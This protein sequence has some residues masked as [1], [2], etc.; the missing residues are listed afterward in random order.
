MLKSSCVMLE[1]QIVDMEA[2]NDKM[3]EKETELRQERDGLVQEIN[4]NELQ[5][6]KTTQALES[7]KQAR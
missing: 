4:E 1:E 7:E 5:L 3:E 6:Q 2:L